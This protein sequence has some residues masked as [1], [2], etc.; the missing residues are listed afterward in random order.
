MRRPRSPG[1]PQSRGNR[2]TTEDTEKHGDTLSQTFSVALRVLRG[3]KDVLPEEVL[4]EEE[5]VSGAFG[6][7]SHEIR[8]PLGAEGNVD[9]HAPAVK[10]M[11]ARMMRSSWVAMPW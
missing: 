3:E 4:E 10:A 11:V 7:P 9:A 5:D 1:F 2:L 6:Q 8:M